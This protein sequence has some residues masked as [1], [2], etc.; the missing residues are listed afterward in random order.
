MKKLIFQNVGV[1]LT[2]YKQK[3]RYQKSIKQRELKVFY[4]PVI[5]TKCFLWIEFLIFNFFN[6]CS[7]F[8]SKILVQKI[9]LFKKKC[10]KF[11][12]QFYPLL[13]PLTPSQY[14]AVCFNENH[15]FL[16]HFLRMWYKY[17]RASFSAVGAYTFRADCN[18]E[19]LGR[20]Y[21]KNFTILFKGLETTLS[22]T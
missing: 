20:P 12:T 1:F 17:E 15:R 14:M 10:Q 22:S 11:K 7:D 19:V 16:S 2:L 5:K 18:Q 8:R 6:F 13:T 3:F 9:V 21:H 4:L